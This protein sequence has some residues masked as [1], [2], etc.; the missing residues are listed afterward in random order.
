MGADQTL[1][2]KVRNWRNDRVGVKLSE[3]QIA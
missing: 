3:R 1:L 2:K